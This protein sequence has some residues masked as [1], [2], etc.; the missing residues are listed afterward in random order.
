MLNFG[1]F[2]LLGTEERN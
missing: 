2:S 1:F